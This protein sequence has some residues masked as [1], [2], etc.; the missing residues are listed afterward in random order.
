MI[1]VLALALLMGLGLGLRRRASR[2]DRL[3]LAQSGKAN[4]LE[5]K[6]V[7]ATDGAEVDLI[8]R[9]VHWHDSVAARY[10]QIASSPWILGEPDPS[11][12][13]CECSACRGRYPGGGRD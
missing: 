13:A 7:G 4:G 2:F 9:K 1:A 12:I 5:N 10:R 6:L 3:S 11:T 8:L